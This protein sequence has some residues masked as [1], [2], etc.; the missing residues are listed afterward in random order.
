[1]PKET[2]SASYH[3]L[4]SDPELNEPPASIAEDVSAAD[5]D[6]GTNK[7]PLWKALI[8]LMGEIEGTNIVALPYVIS[9]SGLVTIVALVF[10]PFLG[11]YTGAILIDCLYDEN[12]AGETVRVRSNYKQLGEVTLLVLVVPYPT[13]SGYSNFFFPL[14]CTL[15]CVLHLLMVFFQ[16]Y[17]C[18]TNFGCLLQPLRFFQHYF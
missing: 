18:P 6:E 14:L 13:Q 17:R 7:S 2:H 1:M 11:F 15:Y 8:N 9:Q 16:I 5:D 4:K 3:L 10:V 12:D